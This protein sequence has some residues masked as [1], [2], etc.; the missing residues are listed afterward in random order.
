[1]CEHG[2]GYLP[3]PPLVEIW[4]G[5]SVVSV[6]SVVSAASGR[7]DESS[8]GPGP[9]TRRGQGLGLYGVNAVQT[10]LCSG[11]RGERPGLRSGP[12]KPTLAAWV[13]ARLHRLPPHPT[14]RRFRHMTV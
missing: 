13:T 2:V 5:F 14:R 9:P 6:I 8:G 1:M 7:S 11:G 4:Q 12:A 3:S 10:R